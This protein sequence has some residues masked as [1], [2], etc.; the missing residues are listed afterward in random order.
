M[1][2]TTIKVDVLACT[3]SD[4]HCHATVRVKLPKFKIVASCKGEAD[5]AVLDMLSAHGMRGDANLLALL[6]V[7]DRG[8]LPPTVEPSKVQLQQLLRG[9]AQAPVEQKDSNDIGWAAALA[10]TGVSADPWVEQHRQAALAKCVRFINERES[11]LICFIERLAAGFLLGR[12][13]GEEIV[14]GGVDLQAIEP[15]D[16]VTNFGDSTWAL[17]VTRCTTIIAAIDGAFGP[18]SDEGQQALRQI[19]AAASEAATKYAKTSP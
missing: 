9:G 6:G 18:D 15:G 19:E 8:Y 11:R 4:K 5:G 13:D 1:N 3:Q 10:L 17:D 12:V 14:V 16:L 2:A 7:G